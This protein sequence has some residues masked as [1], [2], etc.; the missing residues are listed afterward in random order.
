MYMYVYTHTMYTC[1]YMHILSIQCIHAVLCGLHLLRG[2]RDRERVSVGVG[3][4]VSVS[5]LCVTIHT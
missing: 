4:G 3:V 5:I 1:I 2:E